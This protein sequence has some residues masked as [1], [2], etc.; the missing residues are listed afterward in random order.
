MKLNEIEIT[1]FCALS[2]ENYREPNG[3]FGTFSIGTPEDKPFEEYPVV[4]FPDP[5]Q[6]WLDRFWNGV[7]YKVY[8]LEYI[9]KKLEKYKN[10]IDIYR[11]SVVE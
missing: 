7:K 9:E 11:H 3:P 1:G 10:E 2:W 8:S 6:N 5:D 4:F